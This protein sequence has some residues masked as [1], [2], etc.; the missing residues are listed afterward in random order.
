MV[1]TNKPGTGRARRMSRNEKHNIY[2]QATCDKR[3]KESPNSMPLGYFFGGDDVRHLSSPYQH[4]VTI[5]RRGPGKEKKNE[6]TRQ[7]GL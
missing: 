5:A 7:N 1:K 3:N 4:H 2:N 6:L